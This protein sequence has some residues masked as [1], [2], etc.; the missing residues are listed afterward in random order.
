MAKPCTLH[1]IPQAE[2]FFKIETANVRGRGGRP[3]VLSLGGLKGGYSLSPETSVINCNGCFADIIDNTNDDLLQKGTFHADL[4][5]TD[6]P[7]ESL[8]RFLIL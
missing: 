7:E 1:P 4:F 8:I 5:I 2:Q 3:L 6:V